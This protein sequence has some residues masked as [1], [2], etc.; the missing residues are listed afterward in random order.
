MGYQKKPWEDIPIEVLIEFEREKE[1]MRER[2]RPRIYA[3]A[4]LPPIFENT[5]Q[6]EE[7]GDVITIKI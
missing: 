2:S 6:D 7:S 3:P 1:R 4:P 5:E